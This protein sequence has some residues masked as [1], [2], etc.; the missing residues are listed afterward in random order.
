MPKHIF[1]VHGDPDAQITLEGKLKKEIEGIEIH[2]PEY[3]QEYT[4]DEGLEVEQ[5][6]TNPA[7]KELDKLELIEKMQNLETEL[8]QMK[9]ALKEDI[10]LSTSSDEDMA[11]LNNRV[12]DLRTQIIQI[13]NGK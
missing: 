13:M 1:L 6:F 7:Q 9:H 11:K 8:E 4:L 3:G 12:N 5:R 10:R 2:I